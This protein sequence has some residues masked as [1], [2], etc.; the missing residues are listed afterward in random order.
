MNYTPSLITILSLFLWGC[1]KDPI[2]VQK[3]VPKDYEGQH[4]RWTLPD[5]WK[6]VEVDNNMQMAAFSINDGDQNYKFTI[7]TFSGGGGTD[8]D[9]LNRWFGQLGKPPANTTVLANY[10]KNRFFGTHTFQFFDLTDAEN[11]ENKQFFTA[12]LRENNRS[13]FFKLEGVGV[14]FK[15]QKTAFQGFLASVRLQ[16]EPEE[17]AEP[18]APQAVS[19]VGGV[20]IARKTDAPPGAPPPPSGPPPLPPGGLPPPP[21]IPPEVLEKMRNTP[22]P[23]IPTQIQ[24]QLA[25]VKTPAWEVP[26]GWKVLPSTPMRRGNFSIQG[27]G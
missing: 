25:S 19:A 7:S 21:P 22:P 14:G 13:W 23:S 11:S 24:K 12:I 2:T 9:N 4:L 26:E 18:S 27:E 20:K 8:L 5:G 10:R 17:L 1:G 3:N 15:K 6:N 16:G